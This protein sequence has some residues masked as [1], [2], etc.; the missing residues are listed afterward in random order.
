MSSNALPNLETIDDSGFD[1]FQDISNIEVFFLNFTSIENT[2]RRFNHKCPVQKFRTLLK[3]KIMNQKL[4]YVGNCKVHFASSIWAQSLPS[5]TSHALVSAQTCNK[6]ITAHYSYL[7]KNEA[8]NEIF[9]WT[10]MQTRMSWWRWSRRILH[11]LSWVLF[12]PFFRIR[13]GVRIYWQRTV[14]SFHNSKECFQNTSEWIRYNV[15]E[16]VVSKIM[17]VCL[18]I[19]KNK[20]F[21]PSLYRMW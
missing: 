6:Q 15:G 20:H 3:M 5:S 16:R 4:W 19:L 17:F 8:M 14:S 13:F 12:F 9:R 11:P 18:L 10:K 1:E 21:G 2:L 7:F